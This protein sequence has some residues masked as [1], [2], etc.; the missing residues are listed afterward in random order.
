[1]RVRE[2]LP[3]SDRLRYGVSH[4]MVFSHRRAVP[5]A[6]GCAGTEADDQYISI[7]SLIQEA[8][9]LNSGG[10][11][12][13]ALPKYLEAQKA[14]QQFQKGYPEWNPN[15]IKFRLNYVAAKIAEVSPRVP[16]A[17]RHQ[18]PGDPNGR[19]DSSGQTGAERLG[20]PAGRPDGSSAPVAGGQG[21]AGGKAQGSPLGAARR[22]GPARAGPSGG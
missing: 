15:V 6:G 9:K 12:G 19:S 1:M 11:P 17:G 13:E 2:T 3:N 20:E 8:D 21:R 14:L 16:G 7:H 22:G 5:G 4:E 10:Q 18:P